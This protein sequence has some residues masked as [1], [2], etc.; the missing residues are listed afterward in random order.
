MDED[1]LDAYSR[2]VVSVAETVGPSVASV[3]VRTRR[4]QGAG[5]ASVLTADGFLLTSAHVV[6]GAAHAD[7][8]FADGSE[9]TADL[10]GSDPLSDLAVLRARGAVPA[11]VILGDAAALRVGQLVVALGN[12]LGFA[13][14]VTA[15]IVSALGRSLPTRAGR[16]VDEVIQTDATLNPGNS[17]GALADSAGRVVGVNTAVA[18]IGVGLAVPINATTRQIISALMTQG[19]VRRA[20]LGIAGAQAPLPPPLAAKLGRRTGLQVAEVISGSPAAS[21]GLRVGDIVVAVDGQ[22]AATTTA[23]QQAMVEDSI[24][25]RLEITVWRNGAL[26][27]VIATPRELT[28]H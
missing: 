4:G 15:G 7:V 12:P 24:G 1:P 6:E 14:T 27:D 26:V 11:P 13:G 25:R 2:A 16:V 3:R 8:S 10:I 23:V 28:D 22:P 5:S 9:V 19:R 21:S 17:G 20:W 18:G